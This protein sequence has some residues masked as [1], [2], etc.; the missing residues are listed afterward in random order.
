M[1][2]NQI[3]GLRVRHRLM[4]NSWIEGYLVPWLVGWLVGKWEGAYVEV[5]Y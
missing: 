1:R 2:P 3:V 4:S 5:V